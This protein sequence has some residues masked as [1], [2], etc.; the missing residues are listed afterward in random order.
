[1]KISIVYNVKFSKQH[2]KDHLNL[3]LEREKNAELVP[4]HG[5]SSLLPPCNPCVILITN[6]LFIQVVFYHWS[7]I[8]RMIKKNGI[9][10]M[11]FSQ[12][13][14]KQPSLRSS[15]TTLGYIP[16]EFSIIPERYVINYV[17]SSIICDNQ[18]L[19]TT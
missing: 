3:F 9:F 11:A 16:K 14:R 2:I 6:S 15:N 1:M 5:N 18:N 8:D 13:I 7:L 17:H 4:R 19:E 12:K 10:S